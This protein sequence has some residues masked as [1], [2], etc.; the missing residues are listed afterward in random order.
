MHGATRARPAPGKTER[1]ELYGR[2]RATELLK[3]DQ[4]TEH[5][6]NTHAVIRI[7]H[8]CAPP[9]QQRVSRNAMNQRHVLP[10]DAR[11]HQIT[12]RH[13]GGRTGAGGKQR[14]NHPLDVEPQSVT[15]STG[16][17]VFILELACCHKA[18]RVLSCSPRCRASIQ[19][20]RKSSR[21]LFTA[22][23]FSGIHDFGAVA[24]LL[25]TLH[26]DDR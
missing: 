24:K 23:A 18:T 26:H 5:I 10:S 6:L 25:P 19:Q 14:Q 9:S 17:S 22:E 2:W 16:L 1:R 4:S 15:A 13:R 8:S 11:G 3:Q 21:G 20:R 12:L 7:D